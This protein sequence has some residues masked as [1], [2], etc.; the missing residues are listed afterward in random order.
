MTDAPVTIPHPLGCA[1]AGARKPHKAPSHGAVVPVGHVVW[2]R[3]HGIS[4]PLAWAMGLDRLQETVDMCVAREI[5]L[6]S[7]FVAPPK[8]ALSV[9]QAADRRFGPAWLGRLW[10]LQRAVQRNRHNQGLTL[11]F[12]ST[13]VGG[14]PD[15][16]AKY[17]LRSD[18]FDLLRQ[19]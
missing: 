17:D 19:I 5:P 16:A 3:H 11:R 9:L 12:R 13:G 6:L 4:E 7:V 8:H 15:T 14:N 1:P 2:A 18:A 10:L